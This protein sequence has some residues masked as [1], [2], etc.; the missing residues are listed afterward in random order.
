MR[1]A[2]LIYGPLNQATGGYVYDRLVVEGLRHA[3]HG[4]DVIDL[5]TPGATGRLLRGLVAANYDCLVGDELCY[6]DLAG[7]FEQCRVIRGTSRAPRLVLLVHHLRA[8]ETGVLATDEQLVLERS[9]RVITTS[10]TTSRE[11]RRWANV[12]SVVC[13]PG[14]DRLPP[15]GPRELAYDGALRLLFV[16]TWTER[17]GLMRALSYLSHLPDV[18]FELDVV[19]DPSREPNYAAAVRALLASEPWLEQRTNL[20]GILSD[21]QLAQAYA[22]ADVLVL[23]SSYEGYGIVLSEA[24]HAGVAVIAADVGATSEIVRHERD[25]LLLPAGDVERW[26]HALRQLANDRTSLER[27]ACEARRLPT[28]AQTVADFA[29]AMG[30]A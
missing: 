14:A 24:L 15:A 30:E 3:G 17:K 18:N 6:P 26:V 7:L 27:W 28:W 9:D 13:V 20:H 2:W 21:D 8:S 16:G 4:V 23:P 11:V 19:G 5:A 10:Q 25:G 1:C 22:R 12:P 29:R